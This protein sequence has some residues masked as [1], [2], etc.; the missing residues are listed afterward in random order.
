MVAVDTNV[1]IRLLTRDHATQAGRAAE[2]FRSGRVLILKTVMLE[3]AWVLRYSYGLGSD[4]ILR[5]LRALL[6]LPNVA[7]EDPIAVIT[8]LHLLEQ[9]ID[10]ADALHI[11]SGTLAVRFVTFDRRLV[12]RSAGLAPIEVA[13]A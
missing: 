4:A 7:A 12:K 8:A 11:A 1:V 13:L 3:T 2:I 6:G 5:A 10:F 9:G